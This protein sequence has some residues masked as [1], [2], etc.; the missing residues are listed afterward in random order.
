VTIDH[1]KE[2][3]QGKRRRLDAVANRKSTTVKKHILVL[4]GGFAGLWSAIGAAR[5]LSEQ[6]A[7]AEAE[8]TLVDRTTYHNIRVRNYEADLREVC[9]PLCDVL[10][11]VG[12]R[13]MN[14]EVFDIDPA[15]RRVLVRAVEGV[16]A[17]AYDRLIMA[18]GSELVRPPIPGLAARAFDV[19]TYAAASRLAQHFEALAG[20]PGTPGQF[21]AVVMGA[22]LTGLEVATVLPERL[23]RAREQSKSQEPIRVI[24]VD[25]L[26]HVGSDMGD[27]ARPFIEE[28]LRS[29][30]IEQ[31]TGAS[32]CSIE[33]NGVVLHSAESI[34][35]ATVIWCGG[36]RA[37]PLTEKFLGSR[38]RFGRLMVDEFMR[39]VGAPEVFAAGD[40]ACAKIDGEHT[41]VMSCQHGRPMGRYAGHN[42]AADLLGE[43][44]LPLHIGWYTTILDL[45]PWG[46]V[47]TNGWDRHV[48]ATGPAAKVTKQ[49]INCQ[50]IYP[51]RT[52]KREDI[53]AAAAPIVQV[54]PEIDTGT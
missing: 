41:S 25:R 37:S 45:G 39:V 2:L 9:I 24:V 47:Y 20:R 52:K 6:K 36:M 14:G 16:R 13:V 43:P 22:G 27:S 18:L 42:A 15:G 32:I 28:A 33:P 8:I 35:A 38:D 17:L 40:V 4:G 48:I 19:D 51:P 12:A 53:L 31:R 5:G 54:P 49:T 46:A 29:L 50:R 1:P 7:E 23:Q 26:P 3:T 21:T 30:G 11:P 10:S 34:D 44:L